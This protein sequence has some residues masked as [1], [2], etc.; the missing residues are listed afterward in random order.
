MVRI[1]YN[2]Q[3]TR[4]GGQLGTFALELDTNGVATGAY[5]FNDIST[6]FVDAIYK[7]KG[8]SIMAEY[9]DKQLK[10]DIS[11]FT[12]GTGYVGQVGYL[13]DNNIEVSGRY[14]SVDL[15]KGTGSTTNTTEY[16]LGLSKYIVGHKLKIQS[17]IAYID[18]ESSLLSDYRIRFQVELGI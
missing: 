13:F 4:S 11:D 6:L 16:T 12:S 2:Q 15:A 8:I 5:L 9:A 17:D 1:S 14:T 18:S 3:T 10:E 7:Y